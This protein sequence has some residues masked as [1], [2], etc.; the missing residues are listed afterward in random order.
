LTDKKVLVYI[1]DSSAEFSRGLFYSIF[2]MVRWKHRQG[3]KWN[4][5]I[6]ICAQKKKYKRRTGDN[7]RSD[8]QN[9]AF[10]RFITMIVYEVDDFKYLAKKIFNSIQYCHNLW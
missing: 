7:K 6:R 3:A 1:I 10:D 2:K 9:Q 5:W 8:L 4:S